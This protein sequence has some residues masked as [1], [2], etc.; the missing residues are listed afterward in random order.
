MGTDKFNTGG[1]QAMELESHTG[2]VEIFLV[3]SAYRNW[4]KLC[5]DGSL[6]L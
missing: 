4:D 2:G 5:S 6:G 1:S 3:A